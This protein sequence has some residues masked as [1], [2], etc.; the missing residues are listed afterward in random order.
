M[1]ENGREMLVE[2][3]CGNCSQIMSAEPTQKG[4]DIECPGCGAELTIP[5]Q[6]SI[7]S[8]NI[9]EDHLVQDIIGQGAMGQVFLAS[10]L[11]MNRQVALKTISPK[12]RQDDDSVQ[13]FIQELQ[14]GADLVTP[15]SSQSIMLAI[16][17][18]STTSLC[19]LSM[20]SI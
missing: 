2:F 18:V 4:H 8:G 10:H 1:E 15:T 19:S 5:L 6:G 3:K 12:V 9:I 11:L 14:M 13:Q 7:Q 17:M 16:L 20:A